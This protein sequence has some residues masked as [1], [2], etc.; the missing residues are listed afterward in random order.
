[1]IVRGG[2]D[3][4]YGIEV[5]KLAGVPDSIINRAKVILAEV[6]ESGVVHYKSA[7]SVQNDQLSLEGAAAE[8]LMDELKN[9]DATTL[10]PIEAMKILYDLTEKAKNI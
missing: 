5:A 1:R 7:A 3:D 9:I 10:T 4:S 6:L 8:S 2:T